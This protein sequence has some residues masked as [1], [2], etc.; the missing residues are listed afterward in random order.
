MERLSTPEAK[1]CN[2][3]SRF[4][5]PPPRL[6]EAVYGLLSWMPD[7]MLKRRL[8]KFLQDELR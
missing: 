1:F 2:W 7:L 4:T 5:V 6:K 3:Q 8:G